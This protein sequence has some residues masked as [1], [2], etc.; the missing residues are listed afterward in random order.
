MLWYG[1][2]QSN[3]GR[4]MRIVIHSQACVT[5]H[6]S[7][8]KQLVK[9]TVLNT[10]RVFRYSGAECVGVQEPSALSSTPRSMNH[11]F[12]RMSEPTDQC[13]PSTMAESTLIRSNI[14]YT[15]VYDDIIQRFRAFACMDRCAHKPNTCLCL[16][17]TA[18]TEHTL[19]STSKYA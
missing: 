5:M 19:I 11:S 1:I 13:G 3:R 14:K 17:Y 2:P 12:A 4:R 10:T 18:Q 15:Y 7:A 16:H 8:S 6:N 9:P